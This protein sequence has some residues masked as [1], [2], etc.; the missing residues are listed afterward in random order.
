VAI[1]L[2]DRRFSRSVCL[3][4]SV[5]EA[6]QDFRDGH[7]VFHRLRCFSVPLCYA[8]RCIALHFVLRVEF[9]RKLIVDTIEE[10]EE[11]IQRFLENHFPAECVIHLQNCRHHLRF[12]THFPRIRSVRI[13]CFCAVESFIELRGRHGLCLPD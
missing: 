3:V 7:C 6:I 2:I 4:C 12:P 9:F 11:W 5:L 13:S 8:P 10:T 1:F